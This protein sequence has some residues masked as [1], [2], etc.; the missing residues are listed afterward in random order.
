MWGFTNSGGS[1][2]IN[3]FAIITVTYP[4]GSICTC[5]NGAVTLTAGST[6]GIW[7]FGVPEGG[8]WTIECHNTATSESATGKVYIEEQYSIASLALVYGYVLFDRTQSSFEDITSKMVKHSTISFTDY[9]EEFFEITASGSSNVRGSFNVP[10]P[11]DL[12]AYTAME[13][14]GYQ[15]T[16]DSRCKV[17][18]TATAVADA[19]DTWI[20]QAVLP[21]V[22]NPVTVIPLQ[23]TFAGKYFAF[24]INASKHEYI[25]YVKLVK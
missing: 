19:N 5:T 23:S 3:A 14:Y 1:D 6:S 12:S 13:I 17:G 25:R 8:E 18:V 21:T 2:L 10:M 16:N 4:A 7:A 11:T 9:S 22:D 15:G 24:R 20:A